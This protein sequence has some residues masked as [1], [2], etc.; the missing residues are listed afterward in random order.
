MPRCDWKLEVP[1]RDL[2]A[3]GLRTSKKHP[4]EQLH[5]GMRRN[6]RTCSIFCMYVNLQVKCKILNIYICFVGLQVFYLLFRAA[7]S[8]QNTFQ[9]LEFL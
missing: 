9:R 5:G 6:A 4:F 8:R 7:I 3:G 2:S 1:L